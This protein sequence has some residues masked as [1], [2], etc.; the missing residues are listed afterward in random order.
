MDIAILK[1]IHLVKLLQLST[2]IS[3][4]SQGKTHNLILLN[5]N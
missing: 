5:D 3:I 2:S 4:S 1:A